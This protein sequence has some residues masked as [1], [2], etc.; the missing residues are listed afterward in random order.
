MNLFWKQYKEYIVVIGIVLFGIACVWY[1]VL[2][3]HEKIRDRM[4]RMQELIADREMRNESVANVS[5]LREQKEL[6]SQKEDRLNVV[7]PRSDIVDL[8]KVI[9]GIAKETGN[10]IVIDAKD[11]N[12]ASATSA[13]ARKENTPAG[14]DSKDAPE[15]LAGSLPSEH[16]LGITIEL[17]GNYGNIVQFL[18]KFESMPYQTDVLAVFLSV[19][20]DTSSPAPSRSALFSPA[21]PVMPDGAGV[22]VADVAVSEQ[23]LPIKAVLDTVVYVNED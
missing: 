9:E 3:M 14:S 2:P 16:R 13:R 8:V 18:R 10:T 22:A 5:N 19:E 23:P 20:Q 1:G 21:A 6:V 17:T 11:K 4:N 12:T 7:I 15:S